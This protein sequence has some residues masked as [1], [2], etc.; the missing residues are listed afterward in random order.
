[1]LDQTSEQT[2]PQQN[3][4]PSVVKTHPI[5]LSE[6]QTDVLERC[7][8]AFGVTV[9]DILSPSRMD[10]K[11]VARQCVMKLMRSQLGLPF[12]TI[13]RILRRDHTTI[14]YGVRKF[15]D[16]LRKDSSI[17]YKYLKL[18][19][20]IDVPIEKLGKVII[21]YKKDVVPIHDVIRDFMKTY[22]ITKIEMI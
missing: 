9:E 21:T 11:V 1:M 13:G 2:T 6:E 5:H 10:E 7:S 19:K 14:I 22:S 3:L 4:L 15:E 18:C 17:K 16:V 12:K 20:D 8:M